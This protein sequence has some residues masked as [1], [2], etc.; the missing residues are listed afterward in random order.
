MHGRAGVLKTIISCILRIKLVDV[1]VTPVESLSRGIV[2]TDHSYVR[3][4]KVVRRERIESELIK[5]FRGL[6]DCYR[7]NS[8]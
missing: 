3:L 8:S 6:P 4:G 1:S 2:R 7:T 5:A